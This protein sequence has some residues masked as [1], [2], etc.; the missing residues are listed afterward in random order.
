MEFKDFKGEIV[1]DAIE[2]KL[3]ARD[4]S[5]FERMPKVVAHPRDVADLSALV[6]T[7]GAERERGTD[8]SITARAAGTDMSG[9]PLTTS[10]VA[11]FTKHMNQVLEV[12]DGYAIT[13][14]GVYYRDFEKA[15][16]EKGLLLPSYPASRELAAMG[17]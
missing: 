14:P 4:T 11:S 6:K 17:G 16:L 10:I 1:T 3:F 7:V 5:I 13:E 2:R 8:I 15:T 12:G 9:G